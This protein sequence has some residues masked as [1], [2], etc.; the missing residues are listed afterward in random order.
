MNSHWDGALW[1]VLIILSSFVIYF[2]LVKSVKLVTRVYG[3]A[4]VPINNESSKTSY[5][6]LHSEKEKHT[7]TSRTETETITNDP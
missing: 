6:R 4:L 2:C 1:G 5:T 7:N 3:H